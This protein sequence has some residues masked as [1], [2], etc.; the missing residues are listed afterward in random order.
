M[1][2]VVPRLKSIEFGKAKLDLDDLLCRDYDS[3]AEAAQ[4]LPA[5]IAWVVECRAYMVERVDLKKRQYDEEVAQTYFALKGGA[6]EAQGYGPKPTEIALKHAIVLNP[7]VKAAAQDLEDA[8][9]HLNLYSGQLQALQSKLELVR[10]SEAT[11]R[12]LIEPTYDERQ[13]EQMSAQENENP[14]ED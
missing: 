1:R 6:F 2:R 9:Y 13:L 3:I 7:N 14:E 5:A 4:S 11:R 12:R 8:K 10:S